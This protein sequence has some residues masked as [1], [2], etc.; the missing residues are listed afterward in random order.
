MAEK[1]SRVFEV[2]DQNKAIF[3][4]VV[5][6]TG[7]IAENTAREA[8]G[9]EQIDTA[10]SQMDEV[11][12]STAANAEE[13]AAASEELAA[14]ARQLKTV[15]H[16]LEGLVGRMAT[17]RADFALEIASATHAP[18]PASSVVPDHLPADM[19]DEDLVSLNDD[20]RIA[21]F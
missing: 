8:Q 16:H 5:T 4:R 14:Q 15:V 3:E 2:M 6:L 17:A 21:R 20:S 11:T 10:M 1:Y 13:S 9:M 12:Q 7:E 19:D 18:A